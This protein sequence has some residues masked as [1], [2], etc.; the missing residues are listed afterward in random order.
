MCNVTPHGTTGSP[1]KLIF[2]HIIRDKLPGVED[3]VGEVGESD[4]ETGIL[5]IRKKEMRWQT[6]LGKPP[7]LKYNWEI[8]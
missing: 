1:F 4:R 7:N 6:K 5:L 3:I 2:N 8:K